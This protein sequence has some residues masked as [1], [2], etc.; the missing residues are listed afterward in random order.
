MA[1]KSK[2]FEEALERLEQIVDLMENEQTGLEDAV[3]LYKEG[4]ELSVLCSKK[5]SKAE[6][7]VVLLQKNAEG[8]FSAKKFAADDDD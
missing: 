6:Q 5:L 8:V 3:K 2:T 7:E 1:R 4:V